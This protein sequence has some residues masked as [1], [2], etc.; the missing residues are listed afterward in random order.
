MVLSNIKCTSEFIRVMK[1]VSVE[2]VIRATLS[3]EIKKT[4]VIYSIF[5]C[6][7]EQNQDWSIRSWTSANRNMRENKSTSCP[8]F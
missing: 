8:S 2:N 4:I 7:C 1:M 5:Q 6:G 3:A